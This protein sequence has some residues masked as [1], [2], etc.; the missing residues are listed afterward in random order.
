MNRGHIDEHI[1]GYQ[2][3]EN[4]L[5][6]INIDVDTLFF[7]EQPILEYRLRWDFD[8]FCDSCHWSM[9]YDQ[10]DE[11]HTR[12]LGDCAQ[13]HQLHRLAI[14]QKNWPEIENFK[15]A[16]DPDD[17]DDHGITTLLALHPEEFFFIV[18]GSEIAL[19][20]PDMVFVEP[21]Q[22]TGPSCYR[23]KRTRR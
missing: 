4:T 19:E 11:Y 15:Q 1:E 7:I 10:Y 22:S 16:E 18:V 9:Q 20:E 23:W 2:P 14:L 6:F 12:R 13:N 21:K 5:Q 8:I 17:V 3:R